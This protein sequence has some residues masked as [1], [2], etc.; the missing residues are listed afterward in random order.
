[1]RQP[2]RRRQPL[3][4]PTD[5]DQYSVTA[6]EDPLLPDGG[7][8]VISENWAI[9]EA[10]FGATKTFQVPSSDF[11]KNIRYFHAVDLNLRGQVHSVTLRVGTS[12]G[13]QVTDS[14]EIVYDSPLGTAT[15]RCRSRQVWQPRLIPHRGQ[16]QVSG[17]SGAGAGFASRGTSAEVSL[18]GAQEGGKR[19]INLLNPGDMYRDRINLDF[20]VA[21]RSGS[22]EAVE[23]RAR[24]ST[25]STAASS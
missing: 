9:K 18:V 8:N 17:C 23:R 11:G 14:C 6:P 22:W 13:R 4:A 12:T 7:G 10:K 25:L 21:K 20:R 24:Y 3:A 2:A 19:T 1:M 5:Y 16:T 15:W